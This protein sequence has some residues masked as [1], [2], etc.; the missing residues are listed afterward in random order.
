VE[1]LCENCPEIG[2][3]THLKLLIKNNVTRWRREGDS[4]QKLRISN[5][6]WG[7]L[8]RK[9]PCYSGAIVLA[10]RTPLANQKVTLMMRIKTDAGWRYYRAAYS[11]NGRVMPGTAVVAGKHEKHPTGHYALRY[12]KGSRPIFERLKGA[13]PAEAEA[14]RKRKEAQLSVV[15]AA[16][17]A[18]LKVEP[19]DPQR[20][21][22]TAQLKQFLADTVDRGSLEAAEVYQLACEEFLEVTGRLYV[23][24]LTPEDM[25]TFQRALTARGMGVRMVSNR[26]A[27]VKA[28]LL[29]CGYD[30]KQLP[31]PPKFDKTMPEIYTDNELN[32]LFNAVTLPREN[33][34]YRVLL[35]TGVREQEA[36]HLEWDD[37]DFEMKVVKLRSKVKKWGFRLKDFEE[38]ELPLSDD[39]RERLIAYKRDH[40]GSSSLI[41]SKNGKPDGH[42]LRTLKRQVRAAGLNCGE[43]EGCLGK[44]KECERWFL[45]KFRATFC[46]KMHRNPD[47]DLRTIQALMGHSDLESTMRY[48][49]PAEDV[50]LQAVVN[51]MKWT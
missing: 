7:L 8:R 13:S 15:V 45:H 19:V 11:A 18:E 37:I 9:G 34:L 5:R 32:A 47:I 6:Q 50:H 29:Y 49:R 4:K 3:I 25:V 21:L 1:D 43:C 48:L 42:L 51:R 20:K 26:H 2:E 46:T 31:K 41:F 12:C 16:A 27:S 44:S 14:K 40:A 23:D 28:F 30:T 24:Q 33:I 36:M 10:L 35:Q 22:L 38:R 39:L 17:K